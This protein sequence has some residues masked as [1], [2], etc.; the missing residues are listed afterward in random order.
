MTHLHLLLDI[1]TLDIEALV[2]PWHQ[3]IYSLLVP[4]GRLAIQPVHDS[5]LQVLN[6]CSPIRK[7]YAPFSDTGRVH[8]M[9][10]IDRNKSLVHFTGSDVLR[11]Q[12]PNHASHLHS[13]RELISARSL[14]KSLQHE[15]HQ[16]TVHT[17]LN[18]PH[19]SSV[20]LNKCAGCMRRR[21]LLSRCPTYLPVRLLCASAE[22]F[23]DTVQLNSPTIPS[24]FVLV[25]R[26]VK[27]VNC[28]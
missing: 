8:N 13:R 18:T 5:V 7:H 3:F 9:F 24:S 25:F 11:L 14:W 2:V 6:I 22:R 15:L 16:A 1:V 4:D 28:I 17:L 12:N 26:T 21:S 19:D 27:T 10:A 20:K 23:S